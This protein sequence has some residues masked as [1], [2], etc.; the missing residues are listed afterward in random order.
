MFCC[1]LS[2]ASN[3]LATPDESETDAH[4]NDDVGQWSKVDNVGDDELLVSLNQNDEEKNDENSYGGS[5]N[6]DKNQQNQ[7]TLAKVIPQAQQPQRLDQI[8]TAKLAYK[9]DTDTE[10]NERKLQVLLYAKFPRDFEQL[11]PRNQNSRFRWTTQSA[12]AGAA[13]PADNAAFRLVGGRSK[14][15]YGNNLPYGAPGY[16]ELISIPFANNFYLEGFVRTKQNFAVD[17]TERILG[18]MK[19]SCKTIDADNG[20]FNSTEVSH[21]DD[22]PR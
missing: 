9:N 19:M 20:P 3:I 1:I 22:D 11:N 10:K 21:P 13:Q 15:E 8:Y 16:V 14:N 2:A 4:Y 17:K 18:R 6:V 7:L 5:K 12:I